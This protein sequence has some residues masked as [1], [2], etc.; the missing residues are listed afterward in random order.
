[1]A[2]PQPHKYSSFDYKVT[3]ARIRAILENRSVLNNTTQLAMPFVK[4]TTTIQHAEYL[5]TGNIG[6]TLGLHAI[7]Q[8][9]YWEDIFS[10]RKSEGAYPLIGYTYTPDGKNQRIY[11]KPPTDANIG[12]IQKLFD[13]GVDLVDNANVVRMP[14]PGITRMT[15]GRNKNGLLAS[16]QLEISV[17][18]LTQLEFLHRTFLIPGVGMILE[19]G[20]QFAKTNNT[21]E[22]GEGGLIDS[23]ITN[24]MFPWYS[25]DKLKNMLTRI[26]ERKVGLEEILNCY[27]YPTQGQYM[28]MFGRVA[29]FGVKSNADGSFDVSVKIV[30]PSE[31][32]WAYSTKATVLPPKDGTGADAKI[33][34]DGS[35]SIESYF[36][37]TAA[38][39]NLKTLLD[40]IR[41]GK[42]LGQWKNHVKFFPKGNKKGGEPE[43]DSTETNTSEKT[44]ADSEDAYFMS[45]RFFVNV[46]LNHPKYG[47]MAIFNKTLPPNSLEKIAILNPY[48]QGID[49]SVSLIETSGGEYIDDPH[50]SFVGFNKYLRSVD[51]S[52]LIIVNEEAAKLAEQDVQKNRVDPGAREFLVSTKD[53]LDFLNSGCGRFEKS[54]SAFPEDTTKSVDALDRGFLSAGI[55]LN[56]KGVAESMVSAD[57]LLRGVSNLLDRMNAA[58]R[59]F[60]QLVLDPMEPTAYVCSGGSLFRTNEKQTWTVIDANYRAS[61]EEAVKNL[62]NKIHVFNKLTR[63]KGGTYYGSEVTD[64]SVDLSLPKLMFSQ[65]ATL[66]LVQPQDLQAAGVE[67]GDTQQQ[68][69]CDN[70][71]ISEPNEALRKMFAITSLSPSAQGGQGPDLTIKPSQPRPPSTCGKVNIQSTSQTS[72]QGVKLGDVNAATF[73]GKSTKE[74]DEE[75]KSRETWLSENAEAC[76]KCNNCA[77]LP[78]YTETPT[79]QQ[80]PPPVTEPIPP[81]PEIPPA[82]VSGLCV[83][84]SKER[85]ACPRSKKQIVSDAEMC[86]DLVNSGITDVTELSQML[87][88]L[89]HE[90]ANFCTFTEYADGRAYEGR[91]DLGN[92]QPGDGPKYKGR[93]YIQI[94]GRSNYRAAGRA[95]GLDLE[96][97]P[98]LV[99]NHENALKVSLWYWKNNP[100]G[101]RTK[102]NKGRGTKAGRSASC[103]NTSAFRRYQDEFGNRCGSWPTNYRN[104]TDTSAVTWTINGGQN[105]LADRQQK[106]SKYYTALTSGVLTT[107]KPPSGTMSFATGVTSTGTRALAA[108]VS[109]DSVQGPI[110]VPI[111][112]NS[113][114]SNSDLPAVKQLKQA[115]YSNGRIDVSKLTV[116][117]G[118]QFV[119]SGCGT[120]RAFKEP[121]EQMVKM[122]T[123]AKQAG[124]DITFCEGY[125]PL[126]V[127][128]YCIKN[129]GWTSGPAHVSSPTALYSKRQQKYIGLCAQPGTSNHGW[130]IAFDLSSN[131][132]QLGRGNAA[133]LAAYNWVVANASN[134][135]FVRDSAETWHWNYARQITLPGGPPPEPV[136]DVPPQELTPV[137]PGSVTPVQPQEPKPQC[138]DQQYSQIPGGREICKECQEK[139]QQIQQIQAVSQTTEQLEAAK[140]I[141]QREFPGLEDIFRYIEMF[142]E[143][144]TGNIRCDADG[145]RSNAFGASPGSLAMKADLTMPGV[146][147]MR[148]GEL[149]WIDRIPAFYK[150]FGAFQ[151]MSIE[152]TIDTSGWQTKVHSQF[153][154]LGEQWKRSIESLADLVS[155]SPSTAP[156]NPT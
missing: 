2:D 108:T 64:C 100:A 28:W 1:M 70:P 31:D 96:N 121:G 156:S 112:Y 16:G 113:T 15:I 65:I 134:F 77:P 50:E 19:W 111:N 32:A 123:A 67:S 130:G 69:D 120:P 86:Q 97:N 62:L 106:F 74:L 42:A 127:Q 144:M 41:S 132:G 38:G 105:G 118:Q 143:M 103:A 98:A 43:A 147:G 93:G 68:N 131:K 48:Y 39:L 34:P 95:L 138:T 109:Y 149:F 129:K 44:F 107:S 9:V 84:L 128:L 5:G 94:T 139:A 87:A 26:A 49:R 141:A 114:P 126:E 102:I 73:Q 155:V 101:V 78:L 133:N 13:Q 46:V 24:N 40:D 23:T 29:N 125:R 4:A 14:P 35:N 119:A 152:D 88:Q 90:S 33:C 10:D 79:P 30:G 61:A 22:Y 55:W 122:L 11:A 52:T 85:K 53:S 137:P 140:A 124:H 21:P 115:G 110:A 76:N 145:N 3:D 27:V 89:A 151:I 37:N 81:A 63:S 45:W 36:T 150:A 60:W 153:N 6:F 56:H 148:I 18:T 104:W 136:P 17:P 72:G 116:V 25:P 8:D 117:P 58:T 154:Y 82:Q 142:P 54:T 91:T 99:E 12:K 146:N 51:P 59:N 66:G 83:K 80:T 135:G 20:Q 75:R 71:T 92:T 7:D 57:T 47:V